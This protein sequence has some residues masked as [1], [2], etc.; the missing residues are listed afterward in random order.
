MSGQCIC[1]CRAASLALQERRDDLVIQDRW[2]ERSGFKKIEARQHCDGGGIHVRRVRKNRFTVAE[3]SES[4][5]GVCLSKIV[6][7]VSDFPDAG[8]G[9]G[10]S[11]AQ[12]RAKSGGE[13]AGG[14][15]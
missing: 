13:I 6:P 7:Q 5:D 2:R 3:V 8:K 10:V 9:D 14:T 12:M 1:E 11:V 15:R 4:F